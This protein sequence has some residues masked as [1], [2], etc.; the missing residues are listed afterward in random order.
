MSKQWYCQLMGSELGP[1]TSAELVDLVRKRQLMQDGLVRQGNSDWVPAYKVKGLFEAASRPPTKPRKAA[2]TEPSRPEPE[3][4]PVE[5]GRDAAA[6]AEDV[7][8]AVERVERQ[9]G[10]FCISSGEKLGP[11]PFEELQHRADCGELKPNDRVW[12]TAS[13]KWSNAQQVQGLEFSS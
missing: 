4:T 5:P 2:M 8:A 13:P 11:M 1:Y 7:I 12:T 3:E 9:I 6:V 10:W